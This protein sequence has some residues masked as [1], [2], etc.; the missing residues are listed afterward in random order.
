M[1]E[2]T[3]FYVEF[4]RGS[5]IN[6]TFIKYKNFMKI[7]L[8]KRKIV[9]A[10]EN[11]KN[12]QKLFQFYILSLLCTKK[13]NTIYTF[14]NN[15]YGI[16]SEKINGR[17]LTFTGKYEFIML[18]KFYKNP[19]ITQEPKRETSIK[20]LKKFLKM[21]DEYFVSDINSLKLTELYLRKTILNTN[22]YKIIEYEKEIEILS[23]IR[24]VNRDVY[25]AIKNFM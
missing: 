9:I 7:S 8:D 2:I 6:M 14:D 1:T 17:Y 16:M 10:I 11:L 20:K 21:M 13:S 4:E 24:G 22:I 3:C 23:C 5:P 25:S 12:Y 15:I 19:L 18:D